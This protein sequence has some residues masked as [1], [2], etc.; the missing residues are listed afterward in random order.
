[1][2]RRHAFAAFLAVPHRM[3]GKLG[4]KSKAQ[5]SRSQSQPATASDHPRSGPAGR[6]TN[7]PPPRTPELAHRQIKPTTPTEQGR[8]AAAMQVG[9]EEKEN[10]NAMQGLQ[11]KLNATEQSRAYGQEGR[12][13]A[14]GDE[15]GRSGWVAGGC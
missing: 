13:M 4:G 6:R 14:G 9:A 3:K 5:H 7:R 1:M 12:K 2:I 15:V 10:A 11:V 8:N